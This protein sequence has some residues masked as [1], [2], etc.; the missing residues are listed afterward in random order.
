MI[1]L[2]KIT[3]VLTNHR[4]YSRKTEKGKSSRFST[5]QTNNYSISFDRQ[6]AT[7][8]AKKK[9]LTKHVQPQG[10]GNCLFGYDKLIV[11]DIL[12]KSSLAKPFVLRTERERG[13]PLK[14]SA[15]E[16]TRG[17]QF[18]LTILLTRPN[19][20]IH[21]KFEEN[22]WE[23]CIEGDGDCLILSSTYF[24][25]GDVFSSVHQERYRLPQLF[26]LFLKSHNSDIV[27]HNLSLHIFSYLCF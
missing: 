9:Q 1:W 18:T 26:I 12:H 8:A 27:G 16:T 21:T 4:K 2:S 5:F 3:R 6:V 13:L 22:L 24:L 20:S 7:T 19:Y 10:V 25:L 14:T 11:C 17:G 15:L 23:V